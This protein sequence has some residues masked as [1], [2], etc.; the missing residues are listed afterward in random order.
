MNGLINLYRNLND[1]L[2]FEDSQINGFYSF[3]GVHLLPN[4]PV[5]YVQRTNVTDGINLEDWVVYGVKSCTGE[6]IDI[7]ES[8]MVESIVNDDNGDEQIFWS[9]EN[10]TVDFGYKL[11]YLEIHQSLGETF[12]STPFYLTNVNSELTTQFHFKDKKIDKFQSLSFQC[13][14][15]QNNKQTELTNYYEISTK[16]TVTQVV[17]SNK[18]KKFQTELLG[19]DTLIYLSDILESAFLYV[20]SK[21]AYLFEAVQIPTL[22][23]QENFGSYMFELSVNDKDLFSGDYVPPVIVLPI[24]NND[25]FDV[26]SSGATNLLVLANDS[27]G[28]EPANITY[29]VTTGIT[30]GSVAISTNKQFLIFT[31]N[32]TALDGQTCTYTI[33]DS[34]GYSSQATVTINAKASAPTLDAVNDTVT[35]VN[36]GVQNIFPLQ[37]DILGVLPTSIT[38]INTTGFTGGSITIVSGGQSLTFTPNGNLVTNQTI[39]YTITDSIGATDTATITISVNEAITIYAHSNSGA[40]TINE[41]GACSDAAINPK[42]FFSNSRFPTN[43]SIIYNNAENLQ[44]L[45][46]FNFIYLE[47]CGNFDINPIT[48]EILGASSNQC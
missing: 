42:T 9:L 14:F 1:A 28:N 30:Q 39:G 10:V 29:V 5:K 20:D 38:A 32:G 25:S 34:K 23:S 41:A 36:S 13:W 17:K 46:G 31:G 43:G 2:S 33:A 12:Y 27:L 24:A 19:V 44:I 47:C 15:R 26:S 8:F 3:T 6:K 22:T 21:R 4:N 45:T 40:S 11:I 7:T 16:R 48:G 18:T 37:N 35:L